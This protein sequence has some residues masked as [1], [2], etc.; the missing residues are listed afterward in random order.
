MSVRVCAAASKIKVYAAPEM[1]QM[2]QM[3][4]GARQGDA[5]QKRR[6]RPSLAWQGTMFAAAGHTLNGINLPYFPLWLEE[7]RGFSG[8]EIGFLLAAGTLMRVVAGPVSGAV[9]EIFG[10]RRTLLA[11]SVVMLGGY[12]ALFPS[13]ALAP[14]AAFS[15]LVYAAWGAIS[16][17]S[18][19]LLMAVTDDS[20]TGQRRLS[21]GVARGIGSAGFI[22]ANLLG[23]VLI[24]EHGS[25]AAIYA[26]IGACLAMVVFALML[27]RADSAPL[28]SKGGGLVLGALGQG[29]GLFR[30]PR[31]LILTIAG[32]L[33][34][35]SHAHY[36]SFGSI[37]WRGQG[38][39]G[40]VIGLLWSIGVVAE[41][42]LLAFAVRLFRG[43][44]PEALMLMGAGGAMLRWSVLGFAPDLGVAF[45]VQT[46]HALTFAATHLGTLMALREEVTKEKLPV[47]V[48]INSALAFGP[49][50]AGAA[51]LSG[52]LF[53]RYE[54][55]GSVGEARGYWAMTV[56]AAAGGALCVW[57]WRRGRAIH[58]G[59]A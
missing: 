22:A 21:Y 58:A 55:L 51:L 56:L 34:Q 20:G 45:P 27:E 14:I 9:A 28:R 52:Y 36:Y 43:W 8:E 16:P 1:V 47:V 12:A 37:I 38:V 7:A 53:D 23:G 19:A 31:L 29:I 35:A 5:V 15:L 10:L 24:R 30:R 32:A 39:G 13:A 42:L 50:L 33:V 18:E 11:A 49:A 44:R 48:S 54:A 40:D 57:S 4:T 17:L 25:Q 6:I 59:A 46:L 2:A 41:I 26:L 3:K